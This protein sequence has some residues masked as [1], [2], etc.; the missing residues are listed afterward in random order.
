MRVRNLFSL[1][2]VLFG[3]TTQQYA[4]G[5]LVSPSK[6]VT[7]STT[8]RGSIRC[9]AAAKD[10]TPM[11]GE[12]KFNLKIDLDSPKVATQ[13]TV[14]SGDK[15]VYCRCWLSDTFPLC[16]G[17]HMK[18]NKATGDNVGPLIVSVPKTTD[19]DT[20]TANKSEDEP[21]KDK[22]EGRKKR[23]I[24]G[25]AA[26]SMSFLALAVLGLI[27]K[28]VNP[29]SLYF[30]CGNLSLPAGVA[31]I[32]I[33]A[34]ANDRLSSD[35]YKRLNLALMEYG[36]IGLSTIALVEERRR[37]PLLWLPFLLATVNSVKG[38]AYG[39]LGWDKQKDTG[40]VRDLLSGTKSTIQ[41]IFS[42]PKNIKAFV[43]LAATVTVGGLKL[44]KLVE[45]VKLIQGG[46][47]MAE[48]TPTLSRFVRLAFTTMILYTLKD[49]ADRDRLEGT[50]FIELNY[51]TGTVMAANS[52]ALGGMTTPLGGLAA[53]I[54]AFSFFNG[55]SSSMKRETV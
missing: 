34:A 35:T 48:I 22:V 45:I 49:A 23:V 2:F 42:I 44:A 10:Y 30:I 36:V 8:G 47:G 5:L 37:N 18:H 19:S 20:T 33:S 6:L 53:L 51:L 24:L 43:Y 16:D 46:T 38:Y 28:G 25:Y 41:G 3:T 32:L 7:T 39:V 13:D 55:V 9:G 1:S 27:M 11:D 40:L 21:K 17:T 54:S 52:G 50:T 4:Y 29:A 14:C 12:T 15:N 31:Y 26:T